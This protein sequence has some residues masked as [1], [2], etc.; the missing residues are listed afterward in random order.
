M[1]V[2]R[3]FAQMFLL[4]ARLPGQ[5]V[6][7]GIFAHQLALHLKK[8]SPNQYVR[9]CIVSQLGL[10]F[11]MGRWRKWH[12]NQINPCSPCCILGANKC[13]SLEPIWIILLTCQS[14]SPSSTAPA[15]GAPSRRPTQA[16][17]PR[18]PD[19]RSQV[20]HPSKRSF[21]APM[22]KGQVISWFKGSDRVCFVL[23]FAFQRGEGEKREEKLP[24]W[25]HLFL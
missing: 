8:N 22:Y 18:N 9:P 1:S 17:A 2:G 13:L 4:H 6:A 10:N 11:S 7:V 15:S 19:A 25:E 12:Q 3:G 14:T 24:L 16:A 20:G 21:V 5:C 23:K